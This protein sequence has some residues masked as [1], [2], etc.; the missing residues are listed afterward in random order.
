MGWLVERGIGED[1]ALLV[2]NEH[3]V[4]AK[5]RWPGELVAGQA[6]TARLVSRRAGS[7]RGTARTEDGEDLLVD[8]LPRNAS[9]GARIDIVVTR[10][11]LAER[12][13]FKRAQA[14]VGAVPPADD[15]F[16]AG[17]I[18]RRF[19][20][21]MWQDVWYAAW[22]GKIA[23]PGGSL[24]LDATPGMTVIDIDGDLPPHDLA[25][26]AVP[27]I[28][29]ALRR[30]DLGGS[31]AIDFPTLPSRADRQAID[32]ALADALADWPHER[33]AMNGFGLVQLVARLEG[34]SLLQ[35]IARNRA[36]AAARFL[37]REAEAVEGAGAIEFAAHPSVIGALRPEWLAELERRAGRPV[38]TRVDPAL[39]L[40][41][42]H[43]Q[44][45]PR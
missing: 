3:A 12:G 38:R 25:L 27:A 1:R 11:A 40:A 17:T 15:P 24:L 28:A 45:V 39:A 23:F 18:V 22:D 2:E 26:A 31:I 6:L 33:T 29:G 9:E 36:A 5:I 8:R 43:A 35:R 14:R 44:I 41:A 30:L 7:A 42:G 20:P 32:S 13:R 4:A 16:A 10:A 19:P 34:P 37:L 21:G